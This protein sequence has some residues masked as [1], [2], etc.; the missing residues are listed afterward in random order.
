VWESLEALDEYRAR[1]TS[2]PDTLTNPILIGSLLVPLGLM[3]R[4]PRRRQDEELDARGRPPKPPRLALGMLPI[5]RGDVEHL[6][7]VVALQ[8]RLAELSSPPR[9]QRS[10]MHRSTFAEAMTWMDIHGQFPEAVEHWRDAR[11]AA[12][13][14]VV[15]NERPRRRRRR[16]RRGPRP[17]QG[18]PPE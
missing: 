16:R 1:F 14:E 18:A 15:P 3:M 17:P 5:A 6:R 7:H 11:Q 8:A 10:L 4:R 12:G 9:T 2:A 13:D